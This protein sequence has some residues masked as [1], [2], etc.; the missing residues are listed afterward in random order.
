MQ[1][2][3]TQEVAVRCNVSLRTA[4]RW[5]SRN[6]LQQHIRYRQGVYE[7]SEEVFAILINNTPPTTIG[8][9]DSVSS[10]KTTTNTTNDVQSKRQNTPPVVSGKPE[11]EDDDEDLISVSSVLYHELFQQMAMYKG[12][13]EELEKQ[14]EARV[15][16]L[17]DTLANAQESIRYYRETMS[18]LQTQVDKLLMSAR[19]RNLIDYTSL[20]KDIPTEKPSDNTPEYATTY[21]NVVSDSVEEEDD[22]PPTNLPEYLAWKEKQSRKNK[23]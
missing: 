23:G 9:L 12:K 7:F 2:Y 6:D 8:V 1:W 4:Q 22:R 18:L 15:G 16:D 17:K 21:A 19:E 3:S 20:T 10:E 13:Y 11:P 5:A 14:S